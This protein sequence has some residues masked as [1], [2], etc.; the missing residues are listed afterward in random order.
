MFIDLLK[1]GE[2]VMN[3][4]MR[5]MYTEEQIGSL[6]KRLSQNGELS[7]KNVSFNF[8]FTDQDLTGL[9]IP[10][11]ND[12][13]EE[14]KKYKLF[15]IYIDYNDHAC[16]LVVLDDECLITESVGDFTTIYIDTQNKKIVME[17]NNMSGTSVEVTI[18]PII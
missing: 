11:P 10:I 4:N 6:V 18:T 8:T 3:K 13:N 9:D 2:N 1:K 17:P 15:Y 12:I 16:G 14:L 5:K 7:I